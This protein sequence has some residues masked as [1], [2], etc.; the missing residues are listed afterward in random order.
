MTMIADQIEDQ[1]GLAS[2]I[3]ITG[4]KIVIR[5]AEGD[6]DP[7]GIAAGLSAGRG[8]VSPTPTRTIEQLCLIYRGLPGPT[9][10]LPCSYVGSVDQALGDTANA[11][12]APRELPRRVVLADEDGTPLDPLSL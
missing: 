3:V 2:V 9:G 11:T 5:D 12:I 7:D 10:G 8:F 4:D 6:H 1:Y